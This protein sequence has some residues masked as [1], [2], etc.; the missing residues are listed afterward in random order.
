MPIDFLMDFLMA[1]LRQGTRIVRRQIEEGLEGHRRVGK[2]AEHSEACSAAKL[3]GTQA[4]RSLLHL[5]EIAPIGGGWSLRVGIS[6][7]SRLTK[8]SIFADRNLGA[9]VQ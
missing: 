1:T 6:M 5:L 9:P 3:R 8:S 4:L 7:P 2:S